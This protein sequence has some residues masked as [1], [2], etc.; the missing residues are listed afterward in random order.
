MSTRITTTLA[1]ATVAAAL[2]TSAFAR[3]LG[4]GLGPVSLVD[5]D[6]DGELSGDERGATREAL[7]AERLIEAQLDVDGDGVV[8]DA[9][10][11]GFDEFREQMREERGE[12]RGGHHGGP[13]LSSAFRRSSCA[14]KNASRKGRW[15]S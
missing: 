7:R 11:A 8:S 10:G 14:R 4:G 3:G 6:G 9:E 13:A 15:P 2:S 5:T 1:I 12:R